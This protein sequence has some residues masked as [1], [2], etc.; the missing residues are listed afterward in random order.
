MRLYSAHDEPKTYTYDGREYA[1]PPNVVT[2]V[3]DPVG[4]HLLRT[5][6]GKGL[7]GISQ[8]AGPVGSEM[9]DGEIRRHEEAYL[10]HLESTHKRAM[11]TLRI[12]GDK[13]ADHHVALEEKVA[14]QRT[15]VA[16]TLRNEIGAREAERK[17]KAKQDHE[18]WLRAEKEKEVESQS[19]RRV[20]SEKPPARVREKA[21]DV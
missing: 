2:E 17:Q 4:V 9:L 15:R 1:F 10:A 19:R 14:A 8:V 6:A 11:D 7:D 3:P 5:K 18:A 13:P 20:A 16:T 12:T 21:K